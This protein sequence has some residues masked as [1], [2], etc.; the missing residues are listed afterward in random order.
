MKTIFTIIFQFIFFIWASLFSIAA[1]SLDNFQPRLDKNLAKSPAISSKNFQALLDAKLAEYRTLSKSPD[2]KSLVEMDRE[3]KNLISKIYK[4]H[5]NDY[6]AVIPPFLN[7]FRS[8][9]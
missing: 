6:S 9:G 3:I 4:A 7:E 5:G 8:R 1:L 2:V